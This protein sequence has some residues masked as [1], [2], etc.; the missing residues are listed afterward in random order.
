M[1][2]EHVATAHLPHHPR[3]NRLGCEDLANAVSVRVAV[4]VLNEYLVS[5][6]Q[7]I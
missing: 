3:A 4:A 7:L 1:Q 6:T 2:R 5:P